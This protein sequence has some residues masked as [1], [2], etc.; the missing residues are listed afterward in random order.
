MLLQDL[1]YL[2][3]IKYLSPKKKTSVCKKNKIL[4]GGPAKIETHEIS[5]TL[6]A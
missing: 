6:D 1:T 5:F 2:K 3:I 4:V